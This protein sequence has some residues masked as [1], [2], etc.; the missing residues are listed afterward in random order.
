MGTYGVSLQVALQSAGMIQAVIGNQLIAPCPLS[1][2]MEQE[3][4]GALRRTEEYFFREDG[5]NDW[6][7]TSTI[8]NRTV[9]K[10]SAIKCGHIWAVD[11]HEDNRI[12]RTDIP[13]WFEDNDGDGFGDPSVALPSTCSLPPSYVLDNTD[14]DDN[15]ASANPGQDEIFNGTD[16]DCDGST[17]WTAA[18]GLIRNV[19]VGASGDVWA[20]NTSFGILRRNSGD[21][22]WTTMPGSLAQIDVGNNEVWGVNSSNET[23]RRDPLT[24]NYDQIT[25]PDMLQVSVGDDDTV[26]A[27]TKVDPRAVR[28]RPLHK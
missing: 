7:M 14:C 28:P 4:R 8:P 18:S 24:G 6:S 13:I 5:D 26:W 9:L 20:V 19:S 17:D 3:M 22:S 23:F 21:T 11:N 10:V 12:W 2:R 16:N 27:V 1:L 25:G 15:D